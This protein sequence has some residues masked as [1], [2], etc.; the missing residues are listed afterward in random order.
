MEVTFNKDL[1]EAA[2]TEALAQMQPQVLVVRSTKVQK[3][4]IDANPKL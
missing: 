1:K 2:L 3:E 4:H